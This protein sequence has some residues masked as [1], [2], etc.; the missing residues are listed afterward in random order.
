MKGVKII[1]ASDSKFL[2]TLLRRIMDRSENLEIIEEYFDIDN[3]K[4]ERTSGAGDWVILAFNKNSD[5][6]EILRNYLNHEKGSRTRLLDFDADRDSVD[7]YEQNHAGQTITVD[8]I[9]DLYDILNA[10]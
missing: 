8:S 2:V 3:L 1:L 4:E 5:E 10:K 9:D 6:I 7:V